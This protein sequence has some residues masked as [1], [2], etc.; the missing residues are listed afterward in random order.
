MTTNEETFKINNIDSDL[1]SEAA[2]GSLTSTTYPSMQW[3]W[4]PR[5]ITENNDSSG[6]IKSNNHLRIKNF[7]KFEWNHSRLRELKM[8]FVVF[9]YL[10]K[11]LLN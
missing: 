7:S 1:R 3:G 5:F 6:E 11:N 4:T 9:I 2:A 10:L 8:N